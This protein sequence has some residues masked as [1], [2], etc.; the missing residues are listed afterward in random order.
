M[1]AFAI[2]GSF[3]LDALRPM[4]L[5]DPKPGPGQIVLRMKAA[6]LNY[7]DLLVTK[8]LYNPKFSL[9]LV[10]LSDGVGEVIGAGEGVT[11][12]KVGDRVSPIFHQR[13]ID[14]EISWAKTK[15]ALGG[16][17]PGVLAEQVLVD[18]EGVVAVP[19]HLTDEEAATLP[20]AAVTAW[21]AL[22][23]SSHLKAGDTVLVQGTGGVSI[24]ALQL[25]RT[26]GAR[27]IV[28]SSSDEKLE[29]ARSLGA[30][31]TI[32][33][34][35]TP[36][37]DTQVLALTGG[38]GVD[39]VIE[40]GGEG[41]I[42]RSLRAVRVGGRVSLIGVLSGGAPALNLFPFLMK[43]ITAQ[44]IFV[45]SRAMFEDMNR[46]IAANG[47]RPVVDRVFPFAEIRQALDHMASG[48]HFGKIAL[49]F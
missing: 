16:E 25:A 36:D 43:Q 35:T 29:R 26:A 9:P 44:G 6:S 7:R 32:N 4:D 17:L 42:A 13:W 24:L 49:R 2:Q 1:K 12:V 20:C 10:P 19:P 18:Q 22:F 45:G 31:E 30:S 33:Y 11:R 38:A 48:G 8:G 27:V 14:G 34:R 46:A 37:W 40:V 15:A 39:H 5:P 23:A 28:T 21:N 41:T 47:L 3:G